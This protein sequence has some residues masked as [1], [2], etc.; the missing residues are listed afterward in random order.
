M[1][2][3]DPL[4]P[5]DAPARE[6][7]GDR[8]QQLLEEVASA[9]GSL[10]IQRGLSIEEAAASAAIEPETLAGAETAETPLDDE[11]L[12]R[13]AEVYGVEPSAFFG[14]KE[15]PLSYLAGF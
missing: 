1:D 9:I 10:R 12:R 7:P 14:G 5:P 4:L 3:T 6:S 13:L 11:Q 15:T 8:R 2:R